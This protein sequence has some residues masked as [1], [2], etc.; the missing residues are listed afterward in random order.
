MCTT[1]YFQGCKGFGR[2]LIYY[3]YMY[4]EHEMRFIIILKLRSMGSVNSITS[5]NTIMLFQ[6]VMPNI[7]P[8]EY[9]GSRGTLQRIL[10]SSTDSVTNI[11]TLFLQES[12]IYTKHNFYPSFIFENL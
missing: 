12:F 8:N 1:L 5:K 4:L 9:D 11:K 3:G 10:Q 6:Q 2:N 7:F